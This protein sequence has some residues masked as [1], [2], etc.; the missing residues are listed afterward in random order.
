MTVST[1]PFASIEKES[2]DVTVGEY[3]FLWKQ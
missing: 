3:L 2:R 1:L